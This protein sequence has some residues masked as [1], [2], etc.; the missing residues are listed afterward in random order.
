[1]VISSSILPCIAQRL[2]RGFTLV[3]P[4]LQRFWILINVGKLLFLYFI[5]IVFL[6][7]KTMLSMPLRNSSFFFRTLLSRFSEALHALMVWLTS[8]IQMHII[9]SPNIC[10]KVELTY[11]SSY[12]VIVTDACML[13]SGTFAIIPS[14]HKV[15]FV[16]SKPSSSFLGTWP[17]DQDKVQRIVFQFSQLRRVKFVNHVRHTI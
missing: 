10:V 11:S 5:T 12:I 15:C 3:S 9:I 13:L 8:G 4:N 2:R 6:R 16:I 17:C 1:M 7:I 14:L